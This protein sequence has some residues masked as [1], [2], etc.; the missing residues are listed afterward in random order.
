M[1]YPLAKPRFPALVRLVKLELAAEHS[2]HA[3]SEDVIHLIRQEALCPLR[4]SVH[5]RDGLVQ[6][7]VAQGDEGGPDGLREVQ[8][9]GRSGVC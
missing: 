3:L 6:R 7:E 5:E 1:N 2:G 4:K 8:I 9:S